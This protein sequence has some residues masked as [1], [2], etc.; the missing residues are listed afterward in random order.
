MF[1]G[2]YRHK[3]IQVLTIV[4]VDYAAAPKKKLDF[5]LVWVAAIG[6][7]PIITWGKL[8]L[9]FYMFYVY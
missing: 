3:E 5:T 7:R 8:S 9:R 6:S 1:W 2:S 4:Y